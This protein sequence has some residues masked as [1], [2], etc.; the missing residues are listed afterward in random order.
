MPREAEAMGAAN[1]PGACE[2]PACAGLAP[3]SAEVHFE[4][5]AGECPPMAE[6]A[7]D[8]M[9]ED[10]MYLDSAEVSGGSS[11]VGGD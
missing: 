9:D 8:Q 11:L 1:G 7:E 10:E 2:L 3:V 5:N 6:A 4:G